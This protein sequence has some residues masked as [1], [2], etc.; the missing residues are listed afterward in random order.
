MSH[1][2]PTVACWLFLLFI[3]PLCGVTQTPDCGMLHII[4]LSRRRFRHSIGAFHFY[5]WIVYSCFIWIICLRASWTLFHNWRSDHR[6]F[7]SMIM[8]GYIILVFLM[9]ASTFKVLIGLYLALVLAR[10]LAWRGAL[11]WQP[12]NLSNGDSSLMKIGV[13]LVRCSCW[14]M[15][16]HRPWWSSNRFRPQPLETICCTLRTQWSC[17]TYFV[18]LLGISVSSRILIS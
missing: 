2:R 4:I 12:R 10:S 16:S 5:S 8:S 17:T 1:R 18:L 9:F 3:S 15:E 6:I 11:W 13:N 14:E 7:Q